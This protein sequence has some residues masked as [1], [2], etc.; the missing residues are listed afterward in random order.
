M[1]V[2]KTERYDGQPTDL[3]NKNEHLS[4][5]SDLSDGGDRKRRLFA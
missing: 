3:T 2:G 5:L 1:V 4:D